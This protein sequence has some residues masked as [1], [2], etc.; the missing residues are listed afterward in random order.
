MKTETLKVK[1]SDGKNVALHTFVPEGDVKAVVQLSHGMAEH[2]MRYEAL[3]KFLCDNGIA[4]YAHDH[5]GHGET[6]ESVEDLGF[7]A[8][9]DGF[10]RVVEDLATMIK[11][12]KEDFSGKKVILLA[13]SFGSFVSQCYIEKY[14]AE[15]D[16]VVLCG[17]AGP[18]LLLTGFGQVFSGIVMKCTGK[19]KKSALLDTLVFGTYNKGIESDSPAAWICRDAEVVKK[20]D[21]DPFCGFKVTNE[22][23]YDFLGGLTSIHK[24]KNM[25]KIPKDLPVFLMAGDG[26]PVGEYGKS[27][28]KLFTSYKKLGIKDVSLK[29]YPEARHELFNELNK[30]DVMNDLLVWV[31]SQLDN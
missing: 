29:I 19:R 13:H 16:G 17:S 18:R 2:S 6:A 15:I 27:V 14:G 8:E 10:N 11:K 23:F 9:N 1:M 7:L 25:N 28:K 31:L 24:K 3:G 21:D 12:C 22:F 30:V 20:Y 4:F 5:R 26:D